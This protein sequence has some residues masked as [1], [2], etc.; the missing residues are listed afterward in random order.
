MSNPI[1]YHGLTIEFDAHIPR[2]TVDGQEIPLPADTADQGRLPDVLNTEVLH[3]RARRYVDASSSFARRDSVR[4]QHFEII[5]AGTARWNEWRMESAETRPLLYDA[6]LEGADLS[7]ANLANAN[8]I[9]SHLN[10]AKLVGANFHEANLGGA[11]FSGAHLERANFCRTDLF[12]T[13]MS[14]AHLESANLQGTHL[15]KTNF[16]GAHLI[17]CRIYGLSAWDLTV[18]DSTVQRD[19]IIVYE[20]DGPTQAG[21]GEEGR[22]VVDDLRV[23]QFI[24]L[25]LH[26]QNIRHV[27][28]TVAKTA[29]LILGRFT[30]ERNDILNALRAE[31]RRRRFLPM[32]FDF[33]PSAKRNLTETVATL[34]HLSRFVIADITD[35][36]SVAQ[37]LQHIVPALPSLPVQPILLASQYEYGM[38]RDFSDYPWVLEPY[39]YDSRDHL[40]ASLDNNV[41]APAVAKADEIERRRKAAEKQLG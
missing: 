10:E 27:I 20:E 3:E 14:G 4:D 24:Y 8:M 26:N 40:L 35:A 25:L 6:H 19:L 5:R 11:D 18:D 32:L 31:L 30:P 15:A 12:D 34:A 21:R 39:R 22:V 13:N 29:V 16:T 38:F 17:E 28:D 33:P 9:C 41:I 2:L 7:G 37:E 23:A 1:Y 36:R